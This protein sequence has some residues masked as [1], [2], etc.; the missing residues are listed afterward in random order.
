M[1]PSLS[2]LYS[3]KGATRRLVE[4]TFNA[5]SKG[6][7]LTKHKLAQIIRGDGTLYTEESWEFVKVVERLFR[8]LSNLKDP[9]GNSQMLEFLSIAVTGKRYELLKKEL[10]SDICDFRTFWKIPVDALTSNMDT[11]GVSIHHPF[12]RSL[13]AQKWIN[14]ESWKKLWLLDCQSSLAC[15]FIIPVPPKT[16]FGKDTTYRKY[17][18]WKNGSD[19]SGSERFF[20]TALDSEG[21]VVGFVSWYF[22][23]RGNEIKGTGFSF[24]SFNTDSLNVDFRFDLRPCNAKVSSDEV[25]AQSFSLA[26]FQEFVHMELKSHL[27]NEM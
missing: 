14:V 15:P 6:D 25:Q 18:T 10:P 16:I 26:E 12:P 8:S 23:G 20:I 11:S 22:W 2:N 3:F 1:L 21:R 7:R 5:Y 17:S 4:Y 19:F 24:S 9:V 13:D 27:L